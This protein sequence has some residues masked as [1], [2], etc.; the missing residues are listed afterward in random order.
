MSTK[1]SCQRRTNTH[2]VAKLYRRWWCEGVMACWPVTNSITC[3]GRCCVVFPGGAPAVHTPLFIS[4]PL[5]VTKRN[6]LKKSWTAKLSFKN[7]NKHKKNV[8][9]TVGCP[10][11]FKPYFRKKLPERPLPQPNGCF[12]FQGKLVTSPRQTAN[13]LLLIALAHRHV[14]THT[15]TRVRTHV[16]THTRT[17]PT[18][19]VASSSSFSF[20]FFF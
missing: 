3:S 17:Q 4:S 18:Y 8:K 20:F 13:P 14:N 7:T 16:H 5:T 9:L 19:R 2:T 6:K 10:F 11:F 1:A 12:D 15:R